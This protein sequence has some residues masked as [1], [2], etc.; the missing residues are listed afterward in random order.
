MNNRERTIQRYLLGEVPESQQEGLE[1]QF[2]NDPQLFEQIVQAENELVDKYARGLLSPSTRERF[3]KHYMAHPSRRERAAFAGALAAKLGQVGEIETAS[4]PSERWLD[5]L[6]AFMGGRR[7]VWAFAGVVLLIAVV[8]AWSLV[9]TRRLQ[10]ELAR[11]QSERADRE[12]RARVLEQQ[13]TNEQLRAEK[14][15]DEIERL[16]AEQTVPAPS[17]T[18]QRE[19]STLATLMLTIGGTRGADAGPPAVLVV[20][21]GTEQVKVQLNLKENDYSSYRAAV[22]SAGGDTI[23]T[24]RRLAPI[25]LRSGASL[26]LFIPAGKF[27]TGD[28]M[29][30]LQGFG[31]SGEAEDI[32]KSVFRVE[33]R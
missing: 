27:S 14:L 4:A 31:H 33:R 10:Q 18:G 3:E 25:R 29:L 9:E 8:T 30:T 24:S 15:S 22:Q 26:A 11:S 28:Y 7:L 19:G 6:F 17:V 21:A 2:F 16:R 12:Q 1:Q 20:P 32:S 13:L 23:F 5:R